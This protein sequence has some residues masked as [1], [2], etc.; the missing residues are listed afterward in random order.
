[1]KF[2]WLLLLPFWSIVS[3]NNIEGT[4]QNCS[5]RRT[6]DILIYQQNG[7]YYGKIVWLENPNQT[8]AQNPNKGKQNKPLMNQTIL[9]NLS[10]KGNHKYVD[11]ELYDPKSG[12]TY[13]CTVTFKENHLEL[14]VHLKGFSWLGKKVKW[15]KK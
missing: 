2:L 4:W 1:M 6:A 7:K 8:D 9:G 11:G 13:G 12:K 3:E 15:L 5:E 14:W 10:Y